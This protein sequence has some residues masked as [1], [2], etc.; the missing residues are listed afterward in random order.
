VKYIGQTDRIED[1]ERLRGVGGAHLVG[2][3]DWPLQHDGSN[4]RQDHDKN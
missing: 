4:R 2:L 1:A 3:G